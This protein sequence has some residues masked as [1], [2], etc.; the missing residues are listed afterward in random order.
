MPTGEVGKRKEEITRACAH[1]RKRTGRGAD[2]SLGAS[3]EEVQLRSGLGNREV[4]DFKA[5]FCGGA[6]SAS[7]VPCSLKTALLTLVRVCV[8]MELVAHFCVT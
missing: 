1:T 4:R 7:A 2:T 6:V 8:G 5:D 3:P